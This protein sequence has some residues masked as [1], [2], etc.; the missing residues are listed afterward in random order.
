MVNSVPV[1]LYHYHMSSWDCCQSPTGS[2]TSLLE[3]AHLH[4]NLFLFIN[5]FDKASQQN[6][7]LPVRT[8]H[9]RL[10]PSTFWTQDR[11]A[12]KNMQKLGADHILM[13]CFGIEFGFKCYLWDRENPQYN[14]SWFKPFVQTLVFGTSLLYKE[15]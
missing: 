15:S 6:T 5:Q 7:S 1:I 2:Q 11:Q 13:L 14:W 9:I 10:L 8:M 12:Y 4:L 3:E